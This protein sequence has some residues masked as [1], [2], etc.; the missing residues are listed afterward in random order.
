MY[1]QSKHMANMQKQ[2]NHRT[3]TFLT[4]LLAQAERSRSGERDFR[5]GELL[6][7]RN[8]GLLHFLV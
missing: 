3:S 7:I 8:N 5:S 1:N 2:R 4:Q 6:T